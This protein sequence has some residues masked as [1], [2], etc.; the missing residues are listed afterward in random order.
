VY[1]LVLLLADE[2]RSQARAAPGASSCRLS[3]GGTHRTALRQALFGWQRSFNHFVRAQLDGGG[4]LDAQRMGR[5]SIDHSDLFCRLFDRK[6][7]RPCTLYDP[8]NIA[9]RRAEIVGQVWAVGGQPSCYDV[10][11]KGI[12]G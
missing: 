8:D 5:F 1:R 7:G 6:I 12:D 10:F 11:P 9:S 2:R 4:H 3:F